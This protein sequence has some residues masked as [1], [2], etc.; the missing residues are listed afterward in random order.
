[1]AI[2]AQSALSKPKSEISGLTIGRRIFLLVAVA[3]L[4]M[5]SGTGY[6]IISFRQGLI[7]AKRTEVR[8]MAEAA[9]SIV[10]GKA[11]LA[12]RG[13]IT[14]EAAQAEALAQLRALRFG[15]NGA[16]FAVSFEGTS[17]ADPRNPG[18]EGRNVLNKTDAAGQRY[19]A[20]LARIATI[21][22]DGYLDHVEPNKGGTAALPTISYVVAI[23]EWKW[24]VGT[25]AHVADVDELVLSIVIKL[26]LACGPAGLAFLGFALWLSQGL[27]RP[28]K[29]L[30]G[31]LHRLATGDLDAEVEGDVRRDE[32]GAIA[33]AVATFRER[34]KIRVAEDAARDAEAKKVAD[35][36]R[37]LMMTQLA[38]EFEASVNAVAE[39]V[40]KSA[41]D[42]ATTANRLSAI[43]RDAE[44]DATGATLLAETTRERVC[45]AANAAESLAHTAMSV[46]GEVASS[47]EMAERA[48]GEAKETDA[49][50]RGLSAAAD[51]IGTI[52]ELIRN[53]AAQTNLLALNATIEAARA[54][55]S[56]RGFAVVANEVK[57]LAG[58]TARATESI[59]EEINAVQSATGQ[60][61]QA[62]SGI[63]ET[64]ERI[65]TSAA[66]VATAVGSQVEN[67]HEISI[68][69][70]DA[71]G[72]T[73]KMS[74]TLAALRA[75]ALTT[76]SSATEVVKAADDL[77][78]E[79][80]RLAHEANGFLS[81]LK[82]A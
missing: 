5:L 32:I 8:H 51:Q 45:A 72:L 69:I 75:A 33:R 27:A 16:V 74:E 7:E 47:V 79:A 68:A 57:T 19:M 44:K 49:I 65:E 56:G 70:S 60:A 62:I 81:H 63:G 71:S 28:L 21:R 18:E 13:E 61:V 67:S 50:V 22:G 11:A 52:V 4:I 37:C 54:G 46:S 6:A 39:R 42:M 73:G 26:T 58:Q 35:Q 2:P 53:I 15:D 20:A 29:A 78:R 1:M 41:D 48:V 55:E 43:A 31:S 10:A 24:F 38:T 25:G 34:L 77:V 40:K 14:L 80:H 64:I 3:G 82:A 17:L 9:R 30:T 36:D 23:P 66:Q 76:G 12:R 59:T